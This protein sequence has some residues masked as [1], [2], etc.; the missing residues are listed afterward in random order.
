[1]SRLQKISLDTNKALKAKTIIKFYQPSVKI[2]TTSKI[3]I[4]ITVTNNDYL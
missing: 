4:K 2:L 3:L 1:M